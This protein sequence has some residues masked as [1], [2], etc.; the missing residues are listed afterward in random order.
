MDE[1]DVC[2]HDWENGICIK[3]FAEYEPDD[4]SGAS[5]EGER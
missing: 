3:C 1:E 4:F 2:V 5:D